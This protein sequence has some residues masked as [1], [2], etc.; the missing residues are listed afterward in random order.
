MWYV[1]VPLKAM[2]IN[3]PKLYMKCKK[4]WSC[5]L[6]L[7][8][9][10]YVLLHNVHSMRSYPKRQNVSCVKNSNETYGLKNQKK[11]L[12]QTLSTEM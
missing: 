7:D 4:E 5:L 12:V 11:N 1:S 8:H 10:M 6:N 3:E 2:E 9:S